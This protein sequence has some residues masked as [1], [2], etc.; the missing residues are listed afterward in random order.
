M[1]S[2]S[3][4]SPLQYFKTLVASDEGM[5]LLEAAA[6]IA[7]DEYPELDLDSVIQDM[8]Q[9]A[10]R[11]IRRIPADSA[12]LHRLRLLNHYFFGELGFRLNANHYHDPAN[13]FLHRVLDR[14]LGI[15]ISLAVL[16]LELARAVH[17]NASGVSFPGHFLC[18]VKMNSGVVIIDPCTGESLS[19]DQLAQRLAPWSPALEGGEIPVAMF[20]QSCTARELLARMLRNLKSIHAHAADPGRRL[21]VLDR[22]VALL[23]ADLDERC[24]RGLLLADLGQLREGLADLDAYLA[25]SP[26]APGREA[27]AARREDIARQLH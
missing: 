15:P 11:L 20:L 12:P 19:R 3:V 8:E 4:P 25:S 27:I 23:P 13:S 17:L 10:A 24:E 6:S 16:W 5:P 26:S 14:R 2:V 7:Q 21:Q 18:K 9:R 1:I 22:L